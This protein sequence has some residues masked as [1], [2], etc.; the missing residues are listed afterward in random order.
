MR[1]AQRFNWQRGLKG[2]V[3]Q[4]RYFSAPLD[5][6]YLWATLRYVE[7]NSV[8]AGLV[9]NA[10]WYRWSSA[11]AHC[12]GREDPLL[13]TKRLWCDQ[14][15]TMH[16][17]SSWLAAGDEPE[18]LTSIRRTSEKGLPCGSETFVKNLEKKV[19]R[20]LTYRPQG[21]PEIRNKG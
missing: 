9:T 17:W 6:T 20:L 15:H 3:W 18:H 19:G 5:E 11:A 4:G 10:E 7:R 12:Y 1:Y 13:T 8:R 2:H 21:R 16:E 14:F